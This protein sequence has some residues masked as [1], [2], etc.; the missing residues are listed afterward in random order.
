MLF[1]ILKVGKGKKIRKE[2]KSL[3]VLDC[4]RAHRADVAGKY[5]C[6][7]VWASYNAR[8]DTHIRLLVP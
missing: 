1:D 5:N 6:S 4:L 2:P 7:S 3:F 8:D